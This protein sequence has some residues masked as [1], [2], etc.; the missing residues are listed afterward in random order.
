MDERPD[1]VIKQRRTKKTKKKEKKKEEEEKEVERGGG[2][3]REG[4]GIP[5]FPSLFHLGS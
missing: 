5:F 3:G 4:K 2:M 1:Q